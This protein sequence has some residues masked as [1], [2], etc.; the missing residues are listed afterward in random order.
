MTK[1]EAAAGA[2]PIGAARAIA[3]GGGTGG[4]TG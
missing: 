3:R 4:R 2:T 1:Q